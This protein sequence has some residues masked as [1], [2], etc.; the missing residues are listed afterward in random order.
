MAEIM[1]VHL[2]VS[3]WS[4]GSVPACERDK[5]DET[6]DRLGDVRGQKLNLSS[7]SYFSAAHGI[8][9]QIISTTH[10]HDAIL[11]NSFTEIYS[12]RQNLLSHLL[13]LSPNLCLVSKS[14]LRPLSKPYLHS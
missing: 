7:R 13:L 4:W 10:L 8:G 2:C 5:N 14:L 6:R 1:F 9:Y 12:H 3:K 11:H